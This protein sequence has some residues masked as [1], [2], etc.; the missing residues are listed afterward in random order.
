MIK[1]QISQLLDK[2]VDR[3]EFLKHVG[4]ALVA[5]AGVSTVVSNLTSLQTKGNSSAGQNGRH[6]Y[7]LSS[8]GR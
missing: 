6:G 8:Y 2:E 1:Q 3:K 7:G 4:M 5:V